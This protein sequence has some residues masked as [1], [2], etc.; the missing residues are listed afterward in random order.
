MLNVPQEIRNQIALIGPMQTSAMTKI[1]NEKDEDKA[2]QMLMTLAQQQ[3][4][5]KLAPAWATVYPLLTENPAISRFAMT[6]PEYQ[7]LLPEVLTVQQACQI[8]QVDFS[9]NKIDMKRLALSL[10]ARLP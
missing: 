1:F 3:A 6:N 10:A 7:M 8:A 9:L 5:E 4:G 2:D